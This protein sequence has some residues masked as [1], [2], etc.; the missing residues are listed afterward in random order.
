VPVAAELGDLLAVEIDF[1][2][3]IVVNE[4]RRGSGF[5]FHMETARIQM[6]SVF[7]SVLTTE[8]GHAYRHG[9]R[10]RWDQTSMRNL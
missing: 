3:I 6:S 2:V 7:H 10:I 4:K 5:R 1:R 9:L 8:P